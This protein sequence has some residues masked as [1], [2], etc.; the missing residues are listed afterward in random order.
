MK[1]KKILDVTAG[2]RMMWFDKQNPEAIFSDIRTEQLFMCDGRTLSIT[3]D[4]QADFRTL[5]FDDNSFYLVVFDPPH[6]ENLGAKSWM[7]QKFG[8][9]LP[10]WETDIK[11]GF[12][13]CM[14]V[15]KPN[16]VLVFKWNEARITLKQV[17]DIIVY[18]PLFGHTSGKHGRTKWM[19]FM[20]NCE[21][22]TTTGD[23]D[24]II[25]P[26]S[27]YQNGSLQDNH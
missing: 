27:E 16:G 1:Q 6:I 21:P 15:L 4:I 9:L 5:P 8:Q 13:E 14:R 3:P 17:L 22:R 10:T 19:T 7:A 23:T 2:S 24:G 25:H 12:D 18:R 11:Q 26:I 20:K